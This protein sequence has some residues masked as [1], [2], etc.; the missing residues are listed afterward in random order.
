LIKD[1]SP[2]LN[3]FDMRHY[4]HRRGLHSS[5]F[6]PHVMKKQRVLTILNRVMNVKRMRN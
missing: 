6:S 1:Q 4:H 3:W 5:H 2:D